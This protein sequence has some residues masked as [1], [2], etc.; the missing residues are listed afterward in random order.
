MCVDTAGSIPRAAFYIP[1]VQVMEQ[2]S[3]K[4]QAAGLSPAGNAICVPCEGA[5]QIAAASG[6]ESSRCSGAP[7]F[8]L[9]EKLNV[10]SAAYF[11]ILPSVWAAFLLSDFLRGGGNDLQEKES[12]RRTAEI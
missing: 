5:A 7:P 11:D 9:S 4:P 6:G 10:R 3:P 2:R 1:V 12:G 8:T